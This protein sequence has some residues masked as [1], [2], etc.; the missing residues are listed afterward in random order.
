MRSISDKLFEVSPDIRY[1][2]TY[3]EEELELH[4]RPGITDASS[5][6]S[7]RFEE[8]LVNPTV[9]LLARQRGKIDCGGLEYVLIRYGNFYQLVHPV[10]GGHV[11]VAI[12]LSADP[13]AV[14]DL[15][16]AVLAA[17]GLARKS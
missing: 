3:L 11:S 7:D 16:R 13:V 12:E 10:S 1:V 17:E 8:L 5:S 2:A 6:D 14:A 9:L 15:V 4:Q